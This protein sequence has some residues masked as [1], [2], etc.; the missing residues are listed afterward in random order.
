MAAATLKACDGGTGAHSD[1]VV[2]LCDAI[3][4]ELRIYADDRADLLA[5]AQLHD[6]GKVGIPPEVL[7]KPGALDDR[8]WALVRQ[9][10]LAGEQIISSVPELGEVARLV[11]HSH[12]RWDGG[13]YPDGLSGEQIPLGSRIVFCADAFHAIRSDRAY[14]RGCTAQAALDEVKRGAG[15]QFDPEVVDALVKAAERLRLMVGTRTKGLTATLRSRRLIALLLTLV[16]NGTALAAGGFYI[17][18]DGSPAS[19]PKSAP[20]SSSR[21]DDTG[22]ER[23]AP[24]LT[25][26]SAKRAR[27]AT[28]TGT[29]RAG[30]SSSGA[31]QRRSLQT[32]PLTATAPLPLVGT[33]PAGTGAL[34]PLP[35][36]PSAART[37]H[38]GRSAMAPRRPAEPGRP[39]GSRPGRS[40]EAPGRPTE[41][42]S[43]QPARAPAAKDR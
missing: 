15:S 35:G 13:G 11:R 18:R 38:R 33:A 3:A 22:A 27:I 32:T 30:A 21:A 7:N 8:E 9:H 36:N 20:Q 10:T 12:E 24:K 26:P 43:P 40:E 41:R 1:D 2:H 6:V 16:V 5:A 28:R 37:P 17:D 39:V 25:L 42:V 19:A 14:R 4:D 23:R 29:A 31:T 34:P